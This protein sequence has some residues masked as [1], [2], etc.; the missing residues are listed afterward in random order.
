[1][2]REIFH[3]DEFFVVFKKGDDDLNIGYVFQDM[4]RL[5]EEEAAEESDVMDQTLE[6]EADGPPQADSTIAAKVADSKVEE[7]GGGEGG[8]AKD[9]AKD[10]A[11]AETLTCIICQELLHDC[12]RIN[13]NHIVNNL[14]E[15]YLK[16]TR[17]TVDQKKISRNLMQKNKIT[18]DMLYPKRKRRNSSDYSDS[19]EDNSDDHYDP[20]P[21]PL[22]V[23]PAAPHGGLVFVFALGS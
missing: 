7:G 17:Q 10:D 4:A 21:L 6:Y 3:G 23:P 18:R 22:P 9:G 2:C 19:D 5:K 20:D 1:M 13:K 11:F 14:V 15:A 8:D 12:I 16:D